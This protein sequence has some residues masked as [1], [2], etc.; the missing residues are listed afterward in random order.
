MMQEEMERK[1]QMLA[2]DKQQREQEQNMLDK[3]KNER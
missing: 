2:E 1:R 3:E